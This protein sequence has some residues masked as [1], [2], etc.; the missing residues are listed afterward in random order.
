MEIA[1]EMCKRCLIAPLGCREL[2]EEYINK[3]NQAWY[4][5]KKNEVC[6]K[7]G[8]DKSLF[9]DLKEHNPYF[10]MKCKACHAIMSVS[11][12]T[13]SP[14][15]YTTFHSSDFLYEQLNVNTTEETFSHI[16]GTILSKTVGIKR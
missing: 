9:Y 3:H 5:F 10:A 6:P 15:I 8:Y 16:I 13:S 2:C 12:A 14:L 1:I 11:F 4:N 7:C